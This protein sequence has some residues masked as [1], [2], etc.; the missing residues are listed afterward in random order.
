MEL[1]NHHWINPVSSETPGNQTTI[2]ATLG[3]TSVMTGAET[4]QID[5]MPPPTRLGA[6]RAA[7]A[8][9]ET[10]IPTV[11]RTRDSDIRSRIAGELGAAAPARNLHPSA[12]T[13]KEVALAFRKAFE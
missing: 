2:I 5:H 4:K 1:P 10:S 3:R 11:E 9:L 8:Q 12:T 13:R 7:T 6:K